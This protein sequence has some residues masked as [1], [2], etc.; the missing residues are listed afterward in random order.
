[1]GEIAPEQSSRRHGGLMQL[2]EITCELAAQ[3]DLDAILQTVTNGAC[4]ALECER[5]S[6]YLFDANTEELYTRVVTKLEISEIRQSV[7]TGITGWVARRRKV[8]NIPDPLAD[9]RWNSAIDRKTGFHTRNILAAPVVSAHD[10]RLLGVLQLLNKLDGQFDEFDEQLIQA[11][12]SHAATALERALLLDEARQAHRLQVSVEMGRSIQTSFLPDRL[13]EI[14]GYEVA[15]WWEPAEAVSGDYYDLVQLPDGR[16]GLV[17][18]DVSG[19]GVGPSLIMA[20]IRAMLHVVTRTYS[21]P[22]RILSLLAETIAPD[23]QDG[24]FITMLIVALDPRTH[25]IEFAN[26]GHAPALYFERSTGRCRELE[27]TSL[28]LGFLEDSPI[29]LGEPVKMAPGDLL[30]LATDGAIELRNQQGEIFGRPR[31]EQI[32]QD[33]IADPAPLLLQALRRAINGFH[34]HRQPPDDVTVMLLERKLRA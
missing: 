16:Q 10:E 2:V 21:E 19:H 29:P 5:A 22:D 14:A 27:S 13:P 6:L 18:A 30:L 8:A 28:P 9:A 11:F 26:A 1:M 17:V 20:S 23:L 24:R 25:R 7:E 34:P 32:V 33:H 12:A 31:L 15:A 4:A 3:H